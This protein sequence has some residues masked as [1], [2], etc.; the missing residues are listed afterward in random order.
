MPF[1]IFSGWN[2][3][4]YVDDF[5]DPTGS[6]YIFTDSI[7]TFSNTATSESSSAI[8]IIIDVLDTPPSAVLV[9]EPHDYDWNN[10]VKEFSTSSTARFKF[11]DEAGNVT[12]ISNVNRV[13]Y[14]NY[15]SGQD[16]IK[17]I[18]LFQRN[19]TIKLVISIESYSYSYALDCSNFSEKLSRYMPQRFEIGKWSI[20][21]SKSFTGFEHA[22]ATV[23]YE[24]SLRKTPLFGCFSVKGWPDDSSDYPTLCFWLEREDQE[25]G[26]FTKET[27]YADSK[28]DIKYSKIS[29]TVGKKN[30]TYKYKSPTSIIDIWVKAEKSNRSINSTKLFEVLN[31][32]PN[33]VIDIVTSEG[34]TMSF[35]VP[36]SELL[37][38]L[39]YPY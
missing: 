34:D 23:I 21:Y 20:E 24:T 4:D 18:N 30:Y 16:A 38:Y 3:G 17:I 33:A 31:S 36:S 29:F 35:S 12:T 25:S 22:L 7:G 10:P 19:K 15:I 32:G 13:G 37:E 14:W 8:R 27:Q 6:K 5:G 11:K 2:L 26:L 1:F 9:F 39:K 28:K